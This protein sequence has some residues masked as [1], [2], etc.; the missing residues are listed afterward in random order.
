MTKTQPLPPSALDTVPRAQ[1]TLTDETIYLTRY[2]ERGRPLSTFP[3]S[4]AD[5]A[6]AFNGVGG[7]RTGLLSLDTLWGGV[8]GGQTTIGVYLPPTKRDLRFGRNTLH[9]PLPG[10]IFAGQGAQY[11][12]FAIKEQPT[13]RAALFH[14]PLPNVRENG[15][16]CP[17]NVKFPKCDI[18][19][20]H[21]AVALFFESH[22][23]HDLSTDKVR[24]RGSLF[25]FLKRQQR[26]RSFPLKALRPCGL[27]LDRLVKQF[28]GEGEGEGHGIS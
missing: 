1:L 14:A 10:F 6:A 16:V 17:G 3:I 9:L 22:F 8:R 4:P 15:E 2:D 5:A 25:N 26:A 28:S 7:I 18:R 11:S 24:A 20:L 23:N 19:A 21:Q 27:T 12:I 13:A